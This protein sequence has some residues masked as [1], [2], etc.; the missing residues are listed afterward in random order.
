MSELELHSL[1]EAFST[2][3]VLLMM[4]IF[5]LINLF[6][7]FGLIVDFPHMV[8]ILVTIVFDMALLLL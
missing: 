2:S 1:L 8:R 4:C 3:F 5:H 6:R 7:V